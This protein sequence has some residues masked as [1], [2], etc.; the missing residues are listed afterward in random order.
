MKTECFKLL[1]S[2]NKACKVIL[3]ANKEN[4]VRISIYIYLNA[5]LLVLRT[6]GS[7]CRL[8]TSLFF[9]TELYLTLLDHK[10]P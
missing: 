7:F 1:E 9:L 10:E 2:E 5:F 8:W 3:S 6:F 4:F